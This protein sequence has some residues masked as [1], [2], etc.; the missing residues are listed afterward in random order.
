M[1]SKLQAVTGTTSLGCVERMNSVAL[2]VL[3]LMAERQRLAP[4]PSRLQNGFS[5]FLLFV[6]AL[7]VSS[8]DS[9]R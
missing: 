7:Q 6:D 5:V 4:P 9:A 3:H 1:I 8:S 2:R